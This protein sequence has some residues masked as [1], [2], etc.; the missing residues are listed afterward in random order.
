MG[1]LDPDWKAAAHVLLRKMEAYSALV[2]EH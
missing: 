2:A 1:T